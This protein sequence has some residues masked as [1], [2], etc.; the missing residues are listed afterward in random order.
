[1]HDYLKFIQND[2]DQQSNYLRKMKLLEQNL[3]PYF[4]LSTKKI[5]LH[6]NTDELG[7]AHYK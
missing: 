4:D 5:T 1:M 3:T 2:E 7:P 6:W